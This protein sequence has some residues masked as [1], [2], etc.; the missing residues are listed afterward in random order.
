MGG[1]RVKDTQSGYRAIKIKSLKNIKLKRKRYDLESEILIKLMKK[2]A[3]VKCI[4]I[5]TIY[6][7]EV[8]TVHPVKDTLR[9]FRVIFSK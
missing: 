9:F 4:D 8:S 2:G 5:S 6:G 7:E 1:T 3:K